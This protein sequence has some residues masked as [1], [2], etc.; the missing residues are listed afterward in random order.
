MDLSTKAVSLTLKNPLLPGSGPLVGDAERM[1]YLAK[2]GIGGI[3]TKTI[4]PQG[5]EVAR[6]CIAGKK[7]MIFNS[8]AWSE[9]PGNDW[10]EKFIP[11]LRAEVDVPV[12]A[13]IGYDDEDLK[14]LV[15]KL[16]PMVEGYE[17]IPR[18]VGKQFDEVTRIVSVLRGLT[19]KPIWVKMNASISDPV[20]FAAACK[21]G[22]ANGITAITSLGPN[23]VIDIEN[24][25]PLVGTPDG[26]VWTSGPAIKPLA[27]AYVNMIKEAFPELSLI[28]SGGCSSAEDVI[29][30]LLAGADAVEI[31]SIAMLK[32][33]DMYGKILADLPKA[34]E[35]YDFKSVEDV[36]STGLTK[37]APPLKPSF[38]QIDKAK[39]TGCGL[40]ADNCPYF[41]LHMEDK[42]PVVDESKCFGC[43]LCQTRCPAKAINNV[44]K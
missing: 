12:I 25:R 23:M 20:G 2:Q 40:C 26:Y 44:I 10:Y 17:Y 43:G 9:H 22:G 37:T 27:L 4:A 24:R 8:E 5:A 11:Q 3:V 41:A 18:Y 32:G 30:F 1:I 19:E 28:A 6:P 13:S 7:D 42:R 38:P 21:A 16:E 39:C 15:P 34:L 33:R 14:L 35:K 31:L 36:K 29:E